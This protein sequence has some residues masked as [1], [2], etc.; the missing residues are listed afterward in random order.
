[1]DDQA[2][3]DSNTQNGQTDSPN[4]DSDIPPEQVAKLSKDAIASARLFAMRGKKSRKEVESD[5]GVEKPA[6]SCWENQASYEGSNWSVSYWDFDN[7]AW[8]VQATKIEPKSDGHSLMT[9]YSMRDKDDPNFPG[10][11]VY[12]EQ[13]DN[14]YSPGTIDE[15]VYLNRVIQAMIASISLS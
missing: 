3:R 15:I 10:F 5:N 8:Q 11:Q 1:M 9:S 2:S 14:R 6:Y 12:K 4:I 13:S 7:K